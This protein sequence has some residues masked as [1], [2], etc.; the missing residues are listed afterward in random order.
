[1]DELIDAVL[2]ASRLLAA[3]AARSLA[4]DVT[5]AQYRVLVELAA[6][7]P[8]RIADLA[9]LLRV[10]R[11]TAS[12]MC[13]RLVRK[14]LIARRRITSDRRGVRVALAAGGRELI[15]NVSERRRAE[16]AALLRRMPA[17][18]RAAALD[19]LRGIA[20]RAHEAPETDFSVGWN[21]MPA[22]PRPG[23][24]AVSHRP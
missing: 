12:R 8:Q 24:P 15:T 14:R 22:V 23:G 11:S 5:L 19:A 21:P 10:D 3:V 1:M 20:A 16:V 17:R 9:A 7:G 6:R 18:D 4:E 13:E 2:D